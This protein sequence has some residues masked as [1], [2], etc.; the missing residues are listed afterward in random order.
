MGSGASLAWAAAGALST[1]LLWRHQAQGLLHKGKES[2]K[3]TPPDLE[4][5]AEE[6]ALDRPKN[7]GEDFGVMSARAG[8]WTDTK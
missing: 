3:H 8:S 5:Q 2:G 4:G 7:S 1:L 6:G